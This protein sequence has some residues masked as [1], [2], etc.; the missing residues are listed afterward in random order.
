M[1]RSSFF[2]KDKALF[3]SFPTQEAVQELENMGVIYFVDLTCKGESKIK[4]YITKHTY[5]NYQ[6]KDRDV[7]TNIHKF[8][9]F[10]IHI[11]NII[12]SLKNNQLIYIHCKGGHGRSGIVVA[13]LL[14]YTY[15]ISPTKSIEQTSFFHNNRL[16]MKE[17]WRKIGSPQTNKQKKFVYKLFEPL[18]FYKACKKGKKEGLSNFSLH[19]V[20]IE[21]F[22][23]FPTSEA[24]FQAYKNPNNNEYILKQQKSLSPFISKK[25]AKKCN[26]RE[27]WDIV[28]NNIMYNIIRNKFKQNK[29]I[30]Y[31]LLNTGLRKIVKIDKNDHYWGNGKTNNGFNML[32]NILIKVRN[33]LYIENTNNL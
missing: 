12:N 23:H 14:S 16:I 33:E 9:T 1:Q 19:P 31:K 18:Y 32:G 11:S 22:G 2:I 17:R 13:S 4:P 29:I 26:I 10:I 8:S 15:N 30:Q 5:I 3:G 6:I 28:K 21:K 20:Y 25:L 7:P 24:A 27:D